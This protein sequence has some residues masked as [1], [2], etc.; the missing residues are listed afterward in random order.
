MAAISFVRILMQRFLVLFL[1]C[2][3]PLQVFASMVDDRLEQSRGAMQSAI[4]LHQSMAAQAADTLSEPD[5]LP[6]DAA[7]QTA[8]PDDI[9]YDDLSEDLAGHA[10]FGDDAAPAGFLV[11]ALH[12]PAFIA[13]LHDDAASI[14]PYLPPAARPPQA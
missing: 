2:L 6:D 8:D 11:F 12:S 4:T 14:P 7:A 9:S 5:S 10:S 3:L 1:V 13:T